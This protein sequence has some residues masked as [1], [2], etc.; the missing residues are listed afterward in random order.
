MLILLTILLYGLYRNH[1]SALSFI[2]LVTG[3]V[4]LIALMLSLIIISIVLLLLAY[5]FKTGNFLLPNLMIFS[6]GFLRGP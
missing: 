3:S 1:L 5:S 4:L 6:I 2:A